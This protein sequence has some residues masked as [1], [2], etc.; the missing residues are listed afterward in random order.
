M[1]ALR[2]LHFTDL[3][4]GMKGMGPLWPAVQ[5][6]FLDDLKQLCEETGPVQLVV[7]TGD[8][9]QSGK[10]EEY[11]K[12]SEW[13]QELWDELKKLGSTPVLVTVPGNHDLKRPDRTPV[14]RSLLQWASDPDLRRDFWEEGGA[15]EYRAAIDA[16][17]EQYSHWSRIWYQAHPNP[18][19]VERRDGGLLPGE[20][21]TTVNHKGLKIGFAGLNT[22][23]LQLD[24]TVGQGM[25][26]L[27]PNQLITV[28][29]GDPNRW[30]ARHDLCWLLTHHPPDWLTRDADAY[31]RGEI[32]L[33]QWFAGHLCGHMH[34]PYV[35]F[36]SVGGAQPTRLFQGVSLFGLEQWTDAKGQHESR[37]HG[38]SLVSLERID[39]RSAR[40]RI[41]PRL[42]NKHKYTGRWRMLGDDDHFDL[43]RDG[44][45]SI[46]VPLRVPALAPLAQPLSDAA[47]FVAAP[48]TVATAA[49]PAPR[50]PQP[51][52]LGY[53]P[54]WYVPHEHEEQR[55]LD[56]LRYPGAPVVVTAAPI[57]SKSTLLHRLADLLRKED[58]STGKRGVVIFADIGNIGDDK[59]DDVGAC[60][61]ALAGLLVD[62]HGKAL[63]HM[64]RPSSSG[65]DLLD[66]VWQ[67]PVAP[68][69]RVGFILER[70]ILS[71]HDRVV[72]VLDQFD[73]LIGRAA[74]NPIARMLRG[75]VD[76]RDD[77]RWARLRLLFGASEASLFFT[78][79]DYVSDFFSTTL[80]VR[81]EGF[82]LPQLRDLARLYA[83]WWSDEE[84][85]RLLN[86]VDGHPYLSRL[87]M[88]LE[89]TGTPKAELLDVKNLMSMH[90]T[91][92]LRQL[93]LRTKDNDA[94]L[95]P[96][97]ALLQDPSMQLS[98]DSYDMLYRAGLVRRDDGDYRLRGELL[99]AYFTAQLS[100]PR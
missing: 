48:A 18:D 3:H 53:D 41:W 90:C 30:A 27:H 22:A 56:T 50:K 78:V 46:E 75:W 7:F 40:M 38:Y 96:L 68:E 10:K 45:L 11:D 25:L 6:T 92:L 49:S 19:W 88:F 85:Q 23:F 84:L 28:S 33:P 76:D 15:E 80:Q 82:R 29:G 13:L 17:F 60:V 59:L 83:R 62:G 9:A 86:L 65:D 1:G 2:W 72:I 21:A 57:S 70:H 35:S 20:H 71:A 51:P 81:V 94:I 24:E 89:A 93:W 26:A 31:Y 79:R 61:R 42:A 77:P 32:L 97:S 47:G 44:A 5:A 100:P 43:D 95:R 36:H 98:H 64:D 12:L 99:T 74:A 73:R 63:Q 67:R 66:L 54:N 37:M 87:I 58:A 4:V 52:G 14:V 55:V 91:S 16:A 39:T 34:E 8:L 69:R